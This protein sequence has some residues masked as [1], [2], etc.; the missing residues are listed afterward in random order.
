VSLKTKEEYLDS[1]KQLKRECFMFGERI[2]DIN[3]HPVAKP[4]ANALSMTYE[5]ACRPEYEGLLTANSHIT[6]EIINR[7]T[8]IHH[9]R[10]DLL[11][12]VKM[13]R[14][15]GQTTA[16]CFQRCAGLDALNTMWAVTYEI[17]KETGKDYHRRFEE[18]LKYI[19]QEDLVC[20]AAMTDPKGDRRLTPSQQ[21]DPDA[22]LRI[23]D[24]KSGGIVIR[25]AKMHITG[26][27]NSHEILVFPTRNM[28]PDDASYAVACAVPADSKA[29]TYVY[30]RQASDSRKLEDGSIDT[31]NPAFGGQEALV[32]FQD[33]FVPYERVFMKGEYQACSRVVE[34][35]GSYH[36]SSYGGCKSGLG[37]VLIG[38]SALIA[39]YQGTSDAAHI[40]DKLVDM[41]HMN[42]TLY[43]CAIASSDLGYEL[44]SGGFLVDGLLANVCK[45]HVGRFPFEIA[46][47]AQ[48]IAGG[49]V[50]TLPSEKDYRLPQLAS[51][52]QKYLQG[53]PDV[54]AE[55]RI[56]VLRLIENITM[57]SAAVGYLTESLHGAGSPQA[58]RIMIKR[59]FELEQKKQMAKNIASI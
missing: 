9:S 34:I 19:Q 33:V 46:R 53:V 47:L 17:E 37:D 48:D 11:K 2:P 27:L 59:G 55:S 13:L 18:F 41:I 1:L 40:R 3:S 45:L 42:E 31:G 39:D 4:S 44:P 54:D 23:V 21:A 15:L 26:A 35:F 14:L 30:G 8:H 28:R 20:S 50:G 10:D 24:E 51:L 16:T 57:G 29:V 56:K 7:F 36:R 32:I 25:G 52:L 43:S 22:Y 6:G 58:Q 5:L 38:A 12:K 49:I